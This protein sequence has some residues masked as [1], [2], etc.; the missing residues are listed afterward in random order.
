VVL[1][2][3]AGSSALA[4]GLLGGKIRTG[5]QVV[6]LADETVPGDLY[7]SGRE[8]R[9]EGTVEGDLVAA[10]GQVDVSGEVGGDV[11]ATSGNVDISGRVGGDVRA[12]AGQVTVGGSVGEDL[13]A[14]AGQITVTSRGRIGEDFIFGSG[15]VRVDGRVDGNVQGTTGNYTRRGTIGGSENVTIRR[16]GKEEHPSVGDRVLAGLRRFVSLLAVGALLLWLASWAV[17]GSAGTVRRRP[18]ASLGVGLLGLASSVVLV[19]VIVLVAIL[20]TIALG[21][22][23]LGELAGIIVFTAGVSLLLLAFVLFLTLGFAAQAGVGMALGALAVGGTQ[24][25]AR[26]WAAL[27]VGI[28]A[29]VV[30]TSIPVVGGWIAVLIALA[31]LGAIL[32]GWAPWRRRPSLAA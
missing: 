20:L 15:R 13:F 32:L 23:G 7:A 1:F 10:G 14:A 16:G 6:V 11:V 8:V 18:W 29:V 19:I 31:G 27:I 22:L 25:R 12:A 28:L 21:L 5:G 17:E 2:V 30:L 9:I 26:R 3:L 4:Q 24:S